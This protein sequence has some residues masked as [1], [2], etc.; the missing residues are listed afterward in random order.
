MPSRSVTG[1]DNV[2]SGSSASSNPTR[3]RQIMQRPRLRENPPSNR[4]PHSGQT[5][6]ALVACACILC[7]ELFKARVATK[8][9]PLRVQTQLVIPVLSLCSRKLLEEAQCG[10][11]LAGMDQKVRH[12]PFIWLIFRA[13]G[14]CQRGILP[15][16]RRVDES[17]VQMCR[18]IAG[19]FLRFHLQDPPRRV[20]RG[21]G[22]LLVPRIE[23][24]HTLDESLRD[25]ATKSAREKWQ[26]LRRTSREQASSF[27]EVSLVEGSR[28]VRRCYS[29]I[30]I[31]ARGNLSQKFLCSRHL[32]CPSEFLNRAEEPKVNG[33]RRE[34]QGA[35]RSPARF[36]H[37]SLLG[38]QKSVV[39]KDF[40]FER[41]DF[42][43]ALERRLRFFKPVHVRLEEGR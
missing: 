18:L 4:V 33:F 8:W 13:R 37:V 34:F 15:A 41:I 40:W 2:S 9:I 39:V 26:S 14:F 43:G 23:M 29:T 21:I 35:I 20:E 19:V 24:N 6:A 16:H 31:L 10:V 5:A 32:S 7:Q 25:H 12:R 30:R 38:Q 3:S 28:T 36:G 22:T 42:D 27:G 1:A 11:A 17:H